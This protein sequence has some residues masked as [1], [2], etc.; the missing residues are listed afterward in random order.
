MQRPA[1]TPVA[2]D[3][4][5]ASVA[6]VYDYYLGG[7]HNSEIDREFARRMIESVPEAPEVARLNRAFLRRAVRHCA[8]SGV[9]QFLD[10]GSGIPTVANVHD[11]AQAAQP[12]RR[13]V[14]IDSDPVAVS[15]GEALLADVAGVA[16]AHGDLREP[17]AVL[18][19]R[20]VRQLLDFSEPVALLMLGVL[21]YVSDEEHPIGMVTRYLDAVPSGSYLV[22]SHGTDDA[23]P[24]HLKSMV[25]LS[26][27]KQ[28]SAYLR[29]RD[30]VAAFFAGLE[31]AQPGVV[32]LTE[33]RPE[34]SDEPG[35]AKARVMAYGAVA[36]KP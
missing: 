9:R 23:I 17:A 33:W 36:R 34:P 11:F 2:V 35:S 27:A 12:D 16:M 13:V 20:H 21:H 22:V 4:E 15:Y 26:A 1:P 30:E 3:Q 8:E 19:N 28:K 10:I 25:D 29:S 18:A 14:Y 32:F 24:E 6:G 31:L 7:E 5:R